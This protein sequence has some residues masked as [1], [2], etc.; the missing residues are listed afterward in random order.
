MIPNAQ[1]LAMR[2]PALAATMGAFRGAGFGTE[3]RAPRTLA[4]RPQFGVEFGDED[5]DI[6]VEFGLA[7]PAAPGG[8]PSTQQLHALWAAHQQQRGLAARRGR[9]L[10]PNKGSSVKVERYNFN[11]NQA[12]TFGAPAALFLQGQPATNFRPQRVSCNAPMENFA[13]LVQIQV[14]NV[15]A[16]IGG[17]A[18]AYQFNAN[19]Q[20]QELDLPTLTPAI[21]AVVSGAYTGATPAGFLPGFVAQFI[22]GM[23]GPATVY[24]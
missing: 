22:V 11:V 16:I 6:G 5:L 15:N 12:I 8:M 20:G 9:M 2:D 14:S 7:A 10:E 13:Y 21:R 1:Q 3:R 19:G 17:Q 18:D 23:N 4:H 24:A